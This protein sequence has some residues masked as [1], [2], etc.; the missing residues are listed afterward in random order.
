MGAALL[1]SR[2]ERD[3]V[4]ATVSSAGLLADGERAADFS[5]ETMRTRGLDLTDH[6]SRRITRAI[7]GDTDLVVTMARAQLREVVLLDP[8]AFE[9]CFTLKELVRRGT[10]LVGPRRTD[11]TLRE[12]L[13][14]ASSGR[15]KSELLGQN[16]DDDVE[17][18]YRGPRDGFEKCAFTLELLTDQLVSIAWPG[19]R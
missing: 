6:R 10:E 19:A 16:V 18:P 2:I 14:L 12:W 7:V 5:V 17:D 11:E 15:D 13:A 8:S 3:G 4:D 9:R 1:A